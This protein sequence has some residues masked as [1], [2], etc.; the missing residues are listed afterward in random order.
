ME[1]PKSSGNARKE[2]KKGRV[3]LDE[4]L[5]DKKKGK[6]EREEKKAMT[7]EKRLKKKSESGSKFK[8]EELRMPGNKKYGIRHEKN[9][10][11]HR[12]TNRIF[13]TLLF[14]GFQGM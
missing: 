6:E 2:V 9:L 3:F 8:V 7:E 5:Q 14:S 4:Y 10:S 1:F 11:D 13:D 12:T